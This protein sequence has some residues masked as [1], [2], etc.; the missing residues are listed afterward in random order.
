MGQ[1][2]TVDEDGLSPVQALALCGLT[3]GKSVSEAASLAEVSRTTVHRWLK[4]SGA[5]Q[6]AL[7]ARRADLRAAHES[8][9]DILLTK[10]LSAV[11]SALE[12]GDARVAMSLLQGAGVLTGK[13]SF[14]GSDDPDIIKKQL[15]KR[16]FTDSLN[17]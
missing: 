13:R 10:A 4:D 1:N 14:I 3:E 7:N 2:G 9:L 5:F 8:K 15:R 6:A 12:N 17:W 16:K 11:E